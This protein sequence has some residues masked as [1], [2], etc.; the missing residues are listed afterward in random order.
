[1]SERERSPLLNP[2]PERS[3]RRWTPQRQLAFLD[4]LARGR[5]VA[6]AAKAVGMCRE[7]AY[8]LRSRSDG[9]LFA[10]LWDIA[11]ASPGA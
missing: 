3:R 5:S 2:G 1:M 9:A 6:A 10:A 4:V 11:L 7:G 8:R